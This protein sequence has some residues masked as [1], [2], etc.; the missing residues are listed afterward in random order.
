LTGAISSV[1]VADLNKQTSGSVLNSLSG[2]VAGMNVSSTSGELGAG[3]NITIRGSNSINA[4]TQPLYVIDGTLIDVNT[5]E[6]ATSSISGRTVYNPLA[7]LNP[8]DIESIQVL[9]MHLLLP[10]TALQE[11]MAL[12]LLLPSKDIK[13]KLQ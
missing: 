6:V 2:K 13:I 3:V 9:R 10:Y 7:S 5:S 8:A 4:G 11:Q 1:D 12:L